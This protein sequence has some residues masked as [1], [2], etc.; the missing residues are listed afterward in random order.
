MGESAPTDIQ[1][2]K[3]PA[4]R[5][6]ALVVDDQPTNRLILKSLLTKNGFEISRLVG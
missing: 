6:K 3:V 4:N 1:Q 2:D 5:G